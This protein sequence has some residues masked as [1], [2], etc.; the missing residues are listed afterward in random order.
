MID[1]QKITAMVTHWLETP[2]NS[3]FGQ[4]YGADVRSMLLQKLSS[5]NADALLKKLRLDILL[6]ATL[7][8]SQLNISTATDGFDKVYT[9]L[10]AI[11]LLA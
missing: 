8:D 3:Y 1:E 10:S 4:G 5:D 9:Y 7:D 2:P 11:S 6:M